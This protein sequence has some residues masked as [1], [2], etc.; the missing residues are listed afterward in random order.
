MELK[1]AARQIFLETLKRVDAAAAVRNA[2]SVRDGRLFIKGETVDT[3]RGIYV[4]ALGKAAFPMATAFNEIAGEFIE[5]GVV[6]GAKGGDIHD[7]KFERFAGGHPLPNE[8]SLRAAAASIEMLGEANAGKA[9]VIFLVSGGGSAMMEMPADPAFSLEGLRELNNV[10]VTSGASIA[11]INAV[12][13]A[14]SAVK[15][16]GLAAAAADCEQVSLII[17]DTR[18]GDV[19]TVASGPSLSPADGLPNAAEVVRK[20][21]LAG[22][23]PPSAALNRTKPKPASE[24][25]RVHVLMD[26]RTAVSIAADIAEKLGFPV[27]TDEERD[28]PIAEGVAALFEN[29]LAFRTETPLDRPVC[30]ISGGEFACEVRGGGIGGRNCESVLRMALLANE[31]N[32]SGD[33]AFLSAGTDG[34][35]GNSPAAGGVID[36]RTLNGDRSDGEEH[37]RNSDSFTFLKK[38]GAVIETGPTGTNV[39]D[40]RIFLMR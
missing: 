39:R 12:R 30:L 28:G 8:E 2:V 32:V 35:D 11:E 5:R 10:L 36:W 15:G 19:T 23:V 9:A 18:S 4:V 33:F 25:R 17:S 21:G 29:A 22:K 31:K 13:R 7:V 40:I 34:I 3:G 16:G 1:D 27:R 24:N 37:L 20:Y 26:N 14:V 38:R 6:S